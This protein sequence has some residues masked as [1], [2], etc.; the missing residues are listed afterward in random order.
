MPEIGQ[1]RPAA[2]QFGVF[3]LNPQTR[4]LRK[5][6]VK[7]KIQDQPLQILFLLLEHPGEI[8]TREEIQKRLWPENTYVDFDNAINSAVRK[9]RDALGDSP[10]NPRFIETIAR[11]GYR[12]I[13]PVNGPVPLRPVRTSSA[14]GK[15]RRVPIQKRVWVV[16]AAALVFVIGAGVL[17]R[18]YPERSRTVSDVLPPPVPLTSYPGFQWSPSFSPDGTRVAF[19]WH[20]PGKRPGIYV[21]LIGP[22]DPVRI[23]S[24]EE[25]D[26]AP[27]WSPDGRWIAFLRAKGPLTCA[28]M[29]IP[30]LGGTARELTRLQLDTFRF[31]YDR[32]WS[33]SAPFLAW[34]SYGRWLLATEQ[35]GPVCL[36]A[37]EKMRI[38]RYCVFHPADAEYLL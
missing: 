15:E 16:L 9:L 3:E 25:S 4:E 19:T 1:Q 31:M 29:L 18:H 22:T 2:F 36:V 33:A 17:Y 7:L 35:T 27:A 34:S 32:P 8:V 23:T 10:E 26:F 28:V 37:N 21:K 30:S 5:Q 38:V 11:R 20:E 13:A 6:G 12:F 14:E 24:G